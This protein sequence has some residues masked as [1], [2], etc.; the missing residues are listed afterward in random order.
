MAAGDLTTVAQVKAT[1]GSA[2]PSGSSADTNIQTLITALSLWIGNYTNRRFTS[3]SYSEIRSGTGGT[4]MVLRNP[5]VS[6]IISLQIDTTVIPLQSQPLT[7]G[8]FLID[9]KALALYGYTYTRA[10]NNV[11]INYTAG[12][13]SVPVDLAQACADTVAVAYR[14]GVRGADVKSHTGKLSGEST[15][16]LNEVFPEGA[17]EVIDYYR[18]VVPV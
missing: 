10:L 4:V 5:P 11:F 17:R 6:A 14:R 18:R 15:A 2:A 1:M 7:A 13:S 16:Y 12:Y 3:A 8:Y 9:G